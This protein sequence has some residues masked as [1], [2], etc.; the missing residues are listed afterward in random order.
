ML[1]KQNRGGGFYLFGGI[2]IFPEAAKSLSPGCGWGIMTFLSL[3]RLAP[4]FLPAFLTAKHPFTNLNR[5]FT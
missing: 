3:P 4:T 2:F 1:I 5:S